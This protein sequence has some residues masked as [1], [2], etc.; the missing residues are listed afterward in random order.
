MN[1]WLPMDEQQ[2]KDQIQELL[3]LLGDS[4]KRVLDIGCGNGRVLLPV[5]LAGHIVTGI[6]I[7]PKAISACAQACAEVD[8]DA[9]LMDGNVLDVLPLENAFDVVICCGNTFMLFADIHE[10]VTLLQLCKKSLHQD[11]MVIIDDIPRDLWPEIAEGRWCNGVNDEASLQLVWSKD[12]SV[13]AIREGDKVQPDNWEFGEDDRLLRLW[14]MGDLQLAAR[15][16]ELS[17]P[18]RPRIMP[19]GGGVLVMRVENS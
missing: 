10:G 6:D 19:V 9:T 12:D 13:F 17:P 5:A 8:I 14:T 7:D 2:S 1:D 11:G 15:L 16:S 3:I 18:E 4:P